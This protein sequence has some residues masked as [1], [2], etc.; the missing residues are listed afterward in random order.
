MVYKLILNN[1]GKKMIRGL[2]TSSWGMLTLQNKMDVVT[3]NMAN[4]STTGFKKVMLSLEAFP[5]ITAQRLYDKNDIPTTRQ[6]GKMTL[7]NNIGEVKTS[8]TQ[9]IFE[10]TGTATNLAIDADPYAFFTVAVPQKD[11][12][13]KEFYTRD[14]SFQLT[15]EGMLVTKSGNP[16]LGEN[17]VIV[18]SD[19]QF[20]V[21]TDGTIETTDAII[22]KLKMKKV[23]NPESLRNSGN[24]MLYA[25]EDTVDN[26]FA[27]RIL[28]GKLEMSNIDPVHEMI[29]M[30]T[31]LRAYESNQK[32]IQY[33]DATLEKA[34]NE[35]G[36]L[37]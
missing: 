22:D 19:P 27:G 16:V 5:D 3:N 24:N 34:C 13:F 30:I 15:P 33:Q 35:I 17:G 29:E 10:D 21:K 1:E 23:E 37:R 7:F 11:G 2:Y 9:G 4:A 25:T 28:Q 20:S 12:T 32:M 18:I 31:V 14:G 26:T 36:R 8:F 6:I